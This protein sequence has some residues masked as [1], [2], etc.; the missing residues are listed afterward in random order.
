MNPGTSGP[1]RQLLVVDA[2]PEGRFLSE[3]LL[4]HW[5]Y[6][7]A[8]AENGAVALRLA[9]DWR[10]DGALINLTL[11]DMDGFALCERLRAP[12]RYG[13]LP[14][15]FTAASPE[16]GMVRRARETPR[17]A[18]IAKPYDHTQLT[19]LLVQLLTA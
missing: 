2:A 10:F 4:P 13:L 7:V 1:R 11:P 14:V 8:C 9:S 15:L 17:A 16:A 12:S 19:R 5:G 18:F 3:H 6:D